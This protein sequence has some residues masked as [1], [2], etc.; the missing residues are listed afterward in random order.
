MVLSS[1]VL[2]RYFEIFLLVFLLCCTSFLILNNVLNSSQSAKLNRQQMPDVINTKNN[3]TERLK[4]LLECKDRPLI[5]EKIQYSD[6]WLLKN[7]VRGRTSAQMG[8]S[9]G[10]T[11][12]TN[13]DYTFFDNLAE[14][15]KRWLAPVSFAIFSPGYDFNTTMDCI[16]YVR[17]CLHESQLIQNYVT[18]HIY[19]PNLHMPNYLPMTDEEINKWPYDCRSLIKPYEKIARADMYK[20]KNKLFYPINVGRNI[21]R[22]AANTHFIFTCDIELF[23]SK[24]LI[25]QFF[26][27]LLRNEMLLK[28]DEEGKDIPRVFPIPVFEVNKTSSV[29]ESKAELLEMLK[30]KR[31]IPFH[32]NVCKKCHMVPGYEKWLITTNV[33]TME[34]IEVAKREDEFASWEPFYISDNREPMFDERVTWEGQSNKRIQNY[35]MCLLGFEYHVLHPA[36]LVHTPGI[37]KVN[38][39]DPR[40]QYV[41]PTNRLIQRT[42]KP[43]YKILYGQNKNCKV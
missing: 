27:M 41:A 19:F 22:E 18:F 12:C 13:G 7:F 8:C 29:P 6:Y 35:A 15:V 32:K 28:T 25:E 37:K 30:D 3:V 17:N 40:L 20:T 34:I 2:K 5:F 1:L 16:Q 26:K 21:A 33:E 43:E 4:V 38:H 9:E 23:P 10:I 24:N 31:A 14:V 11:Y 39:K 36:F 42:I